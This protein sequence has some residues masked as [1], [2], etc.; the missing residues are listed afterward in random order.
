L[1]D[2]P[3]ADQSEA[4]APFVID[5]LQVLLDSIVGETKK[6]ANPTISGQLKIYVS[7]KQITSEAVASVNTILSI[8][9]RGRTYPL[10]TY[11]VMRERR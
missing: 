7:E 8:N 9:W 3:F 2:I 4:D 11:M 1:K 6:P 5:H 10:R